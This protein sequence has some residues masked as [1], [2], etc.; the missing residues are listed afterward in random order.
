MSEV[1]SGEALEALT[2]SV[3]GP[4]E[5]HQYKSAW[6]GLAGNRVVC[7]IEKFEDMPCEAYSAQMFSGVFTTVEAAKEEA[8]KAITAGLKI[9]E[10]NKAPK[11]SI[12]TTMLR[13]ILASLEKAEALQRETEGTQISAGGKE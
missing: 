1:S 8:A 10:N 7:V 2:Q 6:V 12:Y 13:G 3:A 9:E 4:V 11:P 5:W